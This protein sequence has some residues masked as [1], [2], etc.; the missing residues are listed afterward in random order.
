[1]PTLAAASTLLGLVP[2]AIL[3]VLIVVI[4]RATRRR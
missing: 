4:V 2:I 3:A 1:M